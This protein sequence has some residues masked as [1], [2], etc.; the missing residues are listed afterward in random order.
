MSFNE[1]AS[2]E[3]YYSC[4]KYLMHVTLVL[5]YLGVFLT[6][7]MEVITLKELNELLN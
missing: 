2:D 3:S 4:G 1:Y 5:D 6:D 7:F